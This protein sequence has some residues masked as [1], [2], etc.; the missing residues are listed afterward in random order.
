MIKLK[1]FKSELAINVHRAKTVNK[2]INNNEDNISDD[3][4]GSDTIATNN[5]IVTLKY[6]D[7]INKGYYS[8]M[9]LEDRTNNKYYYFDRHGLETNIIYM[10]LDYIKQIKA[11]L[12]N[13][14]L[15]DYH[16]K[17]IANEYNNVNITIGDIK[18]IDQQ[19]FENEEG[20]T[21]T[22]KINTV[23]LFCK[24]LIQY[25]ILKNKLKKL[26][27]EFQKIPVNF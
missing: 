11:E 22:D 2:L 16:V 18:E 15:I 17:T 13:N 6:M 10:M 14:N 4:N 12:N 23:K 7:I 25:G 21:D 5:I 1:T 9:R 27:S 3:F 20:W 8:Y 26:E 19:V 24:L